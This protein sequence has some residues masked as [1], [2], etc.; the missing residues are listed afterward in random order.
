MDHKTDGKIPDAESDTPDVKIAESIYRAIAREMVDEVQSD[1]ARKRKKPWRFSREDLIEGRRMAK[2][3]RT[4]PRAQPEFYKM[5]SP[6]E[7]PVF[8]DARSSMNLFS[9]IMADE[10]PA[11]LARSHIESAN[12]FYREI[13]EF[14]AGQTVLLS[15]KPRD[16]S[17]KIRK[18]KLQSNKSSTA[19]LER[20]LNPDDLEP[21][22]KFFVPPCWPPEPGIGHNYSHVRRNM[23]SD[24]MLEVLARL[25]P[26]SSLEVLAQKVHIRDHKCNR[27]WLMIVLSR[28]R[29]DRPMYET[30]NGKHMPLYPHQ[31]EQDNLPLDGL[32]RASCHVFLKFELASNTKTHYVV[33]FNRTFRDAVL[34]HMKIIRGSEWDHASQLTRE[35]ATAMG[36]PPHDPCGYMIMPNRIKF[37]VPTELKAKYKFHVRLSKDEDGAIFLEFV[38]TDQDKNH[39]DDQ[40]IIRITRGA[41]TPENSRVQ[42]DSS[43]NKY[44]NR[45]VGYY[46][47]GRGRGRSR[48][49]ATASL[50][51]SNNA[52]AGG[53]GGGSGSAA[54]FLPSA[55]SSSFS[56][57]IRT[58]ASTAR[59]QGLNRNVAVGASGHG[60]RLP[61]RRR[62]GT[63]GRGRGG[64]NATYVQFK[65]PQELPRSASSSANKEWYE[66]MKQKYKLTPPR[67]DSD[68]YIEEH[69]HEVKWTKSRRNSSTPEADAPHE[70]KT[71]TPEADTKQSQ[72]SKEK[73]DTLVRDLV[74]EVRWGCPRNESSSS[75]SDAMKPIAKAISAC[76]TRQPTAKNR[77]I[78][79][80]NPAVTGIT[81]TFCG[82]GVDRPD[83]MIALIRGVD[84]DKDFDHYKYLAEAFIK[85]EPCA[86]TQD[87]WFRVGMMRSWMEDDKAKREDFEEQGQYFFE[88]L[89]ITW[90]NSKSK[91]P[92]DIARAMKK[93]AIF[94]GSLLRSLF[95]FYVGLDP[96]TSKLALP[97]KRHLSVFEF[98]SV[99]MRHGVSALL[100]GGQDRLVDWLQHGPTSS[101]EDKKAPSRSKRPA[102][103]K[104]KSR[105][106][107]DS[108]PSINPEQET[109]GKAAAEPP[110][111]VELDPDSSSADFG[112]FLFEIEPC[113]LFRVEDFDTEF[114]KFQIG[115]EENAKAKGPD[116]VT[117][118]IKHIN[119]SDT[120]SILLRTISII[121]GE[122][123]HAS[124]EAQNRHI[125]SGG[126][127][128]LIDTPNGEKAN[129]SLQI[130]LGAQIKTGTSEA[131]VCGLECFLLNHSRSKVVSIEDE[132]ASAGPGSVTALFNR[133]RGY[134]EVSIN[135]VTIG[136]TCDVPWVKESVLRI[137][138]HPK[139]FDTDRDFSV[140]VNPQRKTVN[141]QAF[142]G[143]IVKKV[144]N[145]VRLPRQVREW[146]QAD[147]DRVQ[148]GWSEPLDSPFMIQGAV[149][150]VRLLKAFG[151]IQ[152]VD[153]AQVEQSYLS[154]LP[155]HEPERKSEMSSHQNE[156]QVDFYD[157]N[158][159]G[160]LSIGTASNPCIEHTYALRLTGNDITDR[161]S[162]AV[163]CYKLKHQAPTYRHLLNG[164][165]PL[166]RTLPAVI[167]NVF[168]RCVNADDTYQV[169]QNNAE[170][171]IDI[172]ARFVAHDALSHVVMLL[173]TIRTHKTEAGL[174]AEVQA[175]AQAQEHS[176]AMGV[177]L[178]DS[179]E[180]I[181]HH[182]P[183]FGS[184]PEQL[185][186]QQFHRD[187]TL[188][189]HPSDRAL[190]P[191]TGM[192]D[193]GAVF[194]PGE[195][196]IRVHER[197]KRQTSSSSSASA[198]SSRSAEAMLLSNSLPTPGG[199][200]SVLLR[201]AR[202]SQE[203]IQALMAPTWEKLRQ[204]TFRR[205]RNTTG[206]VRQVCA[207]RRNT[208]RGHERITICSSSTERLG[209]AK[210]LTDGANAK[211][212]CSQPEACPMMPWTA[213]HGPL[214]LIHNIH[215][216]P[217]RRPE[218]KL[219]EMIYSRVVCWVPSY[220]MKTTGCTPDM[221]IFGIGE[222]HNASHCRNSTSPVVAQRIEALLTL[223]NPMIGSG[224]FTQTEWDVD[225]LVADG[226][227]PGP[228]EDMWTE[229]TEE[230]KEDR[231]EKEADTDL[232]DTKD[233]FYSY[234]LHA[235]ST[236]ECASRSTHE[237]AI[238]IRS[239]VRSVFEQEAKAG[240]RFGSSTRALHELGTALRKRLSFCGLASNETVVEAIVVRLQNRIDRYLSLEQEEMS[241]SDWIRVLTVGPAGESIDPDL[242]FDLFDYRD[243]CLPKWSQGQ[244]YGSFASLSEETLHALI[245]RLALLD[246]EE[247]YNP[248][249]G[250]VAGRMS[251]GFAAT[252]LVGKM[253]ENQV[254]TYSQSGLDIKT[255]MPTKEVAVQTSYM[256]IDTWLQH[257]AAWIGFERRNLG[258]RPIRFF[259]HTPCGTV[260]VYDWKQKK[261]FCIR[262]SNKQKALTILK[263]AIT[264]E[265]MATHGYDYLTPEF[266]EKSLQRFLAE[267]RLL[268]KNVH[269]HDVQKDFRV[270]VT[271]PQF[272]DLSGNMYGMGI[273]IRHKLSKDDFIL[274]PR[275]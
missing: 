265:S 45:R 158:P 53:G 27:F 161:Q 81:I 92:D 134:Y 66:R 144:L 103:P 146:I 133:L 232:C 121:H 190:N 214:D 59:L 248:L 106:K 155:W 264:P 251:R 56:S 19:S 174:M 7:E 145:T 8:L 77:W 99:N 47:G 113:Y 163:P 21:V 52:A 9:G 46:A 17:F 34:G 125:T 79:Q 78:F 193:L 272:M 156:K 207:I 182:L 167:L 80:Q 91:D 101:S 69:I 118:S 263:Q 209:T 68:R 15:L 159:A 35:Q 95:R 1:M 166:V 195:T 227:I 84:S 205:V 114:R 138:T 43:K 238:C 208:V 111:L 175:M 63:R 212:L 178:P 222:F 143:R 104:R 41:F 203:E 90:F 20:L 39:S 88:K 38:A 171:G 184:K 239:A 157:L 268:P 226:S 96:E 269:P 186:A 82:F 13:G 189:Q 67:S 23:P 219:H 117:Q 149:A 140:V 231:E 71:T 221:T 108:E 202:E 22:D 256:E 185:A 54:G 28:G 55:S 188:K 180:L 29:L 61:R 44:A 37:M 131:A 244:T 76:F 270:A 200:E 245:K 237:W 128:C 75:S 141:I 199:T 273:D 234:R 213:T 262:C 18:G 74:C 105:E 258:V 70:D 139:A 26:M 242:R 109:E 73:M 211:G 16:S 115:D 150:C 132:W 267:A 233:D 260:S 110:H 194:L 254:R 252:K 98:F 124:E 60:T 241:T 65:T 12:R 97:P 246:M 89:I 4:S 6:D 153:A 274:V 119:L 49:R 196:I 57:A 147:R 243:V 136:Y 225:A 257:S 107:K 223:H 240:N 162:T 129:R 192:L 137:T 32:I 215:G 275:T 122:A 50:S 228:V 83:D 102:K 229:E 204:A 261:V 187:V 127:L 94:Y 179:K 142:C 85:V 148:A 201:R 93:K 259:I 177:S 151:I 42:L 217:S 168:P 2:L 169:H 40:I 197:G 33:P 25:E 266:I 62:F 87:S 64:M 165:R 210:K 198:L 206:K 247:S 100:R 126:F 224:S 24:T 5:Q 236:S 218:G 3:E 253:P 164:Q 135:D 173:H 86:S 216:V 152:E 172:N 48:Y 250:Q 72:K 181:T 235:T 160:G 154:P 183:D 230:E 10:G 176:R 130:S 271:T 31:A 30:K 36:I 249:T 123:M 14:I 191:L 51:M 220:I 255:N 170:D 58:S 120:L 112:R 11:Y 116:G